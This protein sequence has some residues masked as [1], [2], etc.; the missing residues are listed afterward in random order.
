MLL[1]P[2]GRAVVTGKPPPFP[3]KVHGYKL[4]NLYGYTRQLCR[5]STT[6]TGNQRAVTGLLT[7][8]FGGSAAKGRNRVRR[9]VPSGRPSTCELPG[10]SIPYI[11]TKTHTG[12]AQAPEVSTGHRIGTA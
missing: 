9:L 11:S 7:V 3:Y 10:S 8:D 4:T 2:G 12:T 6:W 1:V 5:T